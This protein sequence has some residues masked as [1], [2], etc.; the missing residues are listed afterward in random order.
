[1]Q[2]VWP[3]CSIIAET[4]HRQPACDRSLGPTDFVL[5]FVEKIPYLSP[6]VSETT[7]G[8]AL[9]PDNGGLGDRAYISNHREH[10]EVEWLGAS[11][12]TILG[13]AAAH[14]I[15]H[16]LMGSSTHS[17]SG[18]MR[19]EWDVKDLVR[20]RQGGLRFTNDQVKQV[21]AGVLARM[22]QQAPVETAVLR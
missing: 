14:E 4:G 10:D 3:D 7:L 2:V 6:K 21:N 12:E 9:V 13:L 11:S 17:Y 22:T 1:V 16:L 20:A 18:L 8:F 5:N 15:G 19:A